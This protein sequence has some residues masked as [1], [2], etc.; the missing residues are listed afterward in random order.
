MSRIIYVD[1]DDTICYYDENRVYTEAK[2]YAERINTINKLFDEGNV[3][4]YWTARGTTTNIDWTDLTKAQLSDWGA[5]YTELRFK[6]PDYDIIV[7]DKAI[8]PDT[9]FADISVL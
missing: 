8:H 5:K 3:I 2:P 6:K 7:D 9:F 1:I 4:V